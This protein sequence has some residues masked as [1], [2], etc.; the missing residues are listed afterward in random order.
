MRNCAALCPDECSS[1][2]WEV[3]H[4]KD[5]QWEANQLI[6]IECGKRSLINRFHMYIIIRNWVYYSYY[7]AYCVAEHTNV[8]TPSLEG[9]PQNTKGCNEFGCPNTCYCSDH[10]SWERCKISPPPL[11]CLYRTGSAW[12]WSSRWWTAKKIGKKLVVTFNHMK[13]ASY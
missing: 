6:H 7:H 10:C 12:Q 8:P 5:N 9:C 13:I 2:S 3:F 1:R 4:V 11:S